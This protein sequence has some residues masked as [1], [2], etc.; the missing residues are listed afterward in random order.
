MIRTRALSFTHHPWVLFCHIKF[1]L[2]RPSKMMHFAQ[3]LSQLWSQNMEKKNNDTITVIFDKVDNNLFNNIFD[4]KN[5]SHIYQ[6]FDDKK[7]LITK[8][9]LYQIYYNCFCVQSAHME[10]SISTISSIIDWKIIWG[11]WLEETENIIEGNKVKEWVY[12]NTAHDFANLGD[13]DNLSH[14]YCLS[15]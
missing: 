4:G 9:I 3:H 12:W 15:V 2:E 1:Q 11:R 8:K 14:L 5:I 13:W 10:W 7:W 6:I